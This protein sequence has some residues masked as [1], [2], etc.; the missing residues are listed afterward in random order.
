M[1]TLGQFVIIFYSITFIGI[2]CI[3]YYVRKRK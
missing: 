3:E 1:L 2:V